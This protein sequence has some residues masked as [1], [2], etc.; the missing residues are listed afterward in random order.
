MNL[1]GKEGKEKMLVGKSFCSYS[2]A[3]SSL[4]LPSPPLFH[5]YDP[6]SGYDHVTDGT[7]FISINVTQASDSRPGVL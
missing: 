4:P 1:N 3:P 2:P 7:M 6:L 5:L